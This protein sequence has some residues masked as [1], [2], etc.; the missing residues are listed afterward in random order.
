MNFYRS[1]PAL[2]RFHVRMRLLTMPFERVEPHIPSQGKV[3]DFG[4]GFG[5]FS[6][7]LKMKAPEREVV[8]IDLD[9]EKIKIASLAFPE[10]P[11]STTDIFQLQEKFN[12]V[13]FIDVLYLIKPEIQNKILERA[14][15]LLQPG[16]RLVVKAMANRPLWKHWWNLS[17]DFVFVKLLGWNE[18]EGFYHRFEE[19]YRE[20]FK[21]LGLRYSSFRIDRGYP[22]PHI[23]YVAEKA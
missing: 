19:D 3:L 23:L 7:Y 16:G 5:I 18:G 20:I 21:R 10:I 17:Q 15:Q 9:E 2:T 12:A 4:C 1:A 14:V 13:V 22:H 11:F 8:G 6:I